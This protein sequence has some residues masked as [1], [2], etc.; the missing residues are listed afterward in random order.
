MLREVAYAEL[1][2]VRRRFLHRRIA[3]AL[4][5]LHAADLAS[6]QSQLAAQYEAAGMPEQ[7]I[8]ACREAAAIAKQRYAD[9]EAAGLLRRALALCLAFP[10]SA[11]RDRQELELLVTLGPSLAFTAGYAM[12]E[13]GAVTSE[14]WNSPCG[15]TRRRTGFSCSRRLGFPYRARQ[16]G[17]FPRT[18]RAGLRPGGRGRCPRVRHGGPFRDGQHSFPHGTVS[19]SEAHLRK[20]LSLWGGSTHPALALFAG[21]D[22]GVFCHSYIA[23]VSWHLGLGDQSCAS[24]EEAVA[25]ARRLANPFA[26]AIA[27]NYAAILHVFRRDPDAVRRYAEEASEV[28]REHAFAYYLSMAEILAGWAMAELS[29]PA[30][31]RRASSARPGSASRH[32]GRTAFA[33]LSWSSGGGLRPSRTARGSARQRVQRVCVPEQERRGLGCGRSPADP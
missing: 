11:R 22:L 14:R 20:A 17:A 31:G 21:P 1:S 18:R 13:V 32:R 4:E 33:L 16:S 30:G 6:V 19:E 25:S 3:R 9:S 23:H 28:C 24:S 5:E 7:A 27:L 2:P 12:P 15:W 29:A 8:A 26:L 10:E